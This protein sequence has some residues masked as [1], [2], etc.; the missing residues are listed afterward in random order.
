[1]AASRDGDKW[2][3]NRY[4]R[5]GA[6]ARAGGGEGAMVGGWPVAG[7]EAEGITCLHGV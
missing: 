6:R 2:C 4:A 3:T 5:E 1:M 7:Q